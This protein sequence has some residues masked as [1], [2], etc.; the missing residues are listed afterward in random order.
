MKERSQCERIGTK[1]CGTGSL[2]DELPLIVDWTGGASAMLR[3]LG[4]RPR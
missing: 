4:G 3:D 1:G 2:D